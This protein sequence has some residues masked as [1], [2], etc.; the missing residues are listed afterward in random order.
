M[1]ESSEQQRH[2]FVDE[3]GDL[4]L[5]D[6]KGE[7]IVGTPGCSN[8]FILATVL[9]EEPH[10]LRKKLDDL[11]AVITADAYLSKIP[12]IKKTT[13]AFHAK[14][15]CPEVRHEVYKLLAGVSIKVYAIVRRKKNVIQW[16][17]SQNS[18]DPAWRYS[19]DK[20]YD[21][22]V[23]RLFKDRL[24]IANDNFI[25]FA[26]RGKAIRNTALL[27][28]LNKAKENFEKKSGKEI[29]TTLHVIS[30]YPSNEACLQVADYCLWALQRLY[31]RHEDRYFDYLRSKFIRIIDLDDK[32]EKNYGVYYDEKNPLT[33]DK[34]KNSLLG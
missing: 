1:K 25:T 31:E 27:E 23:K 2:Y 15:D 6:K 5:F 14:D 13:I 18:F 30:N 16:V 4:T 7:V 22:C 11:R 21:S 17:R 33:A 8:N 10:G 29:P 24:H 28:A 9:V 3:A 19:A 32:R 12:S 34:I 20:I 26:R